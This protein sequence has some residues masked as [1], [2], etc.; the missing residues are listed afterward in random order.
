[1]A[2]TSSSR[3][4]TREQLEYRARELKLFLLDVDGVLT[5][6]GI[7]LS[8]PDRESKK[9]DVQDGMGI[10]LIRRAGV[11]VGLLTGRVSEAVR[12]RSEELEIDHVYQGHFWKDEALEEIVEQQGIAPE[13]MA[14]VGDDVLDL[15][16]MKRVGLPLAPANARP[17]VKQPAVY[18]ASESG[19]DGAVREIVDWL[20]ELR[21]E[22]QKLYRYFAREID[23]LE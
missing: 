11:E 9:F 3:N 18:V 1:M 2:S 14:Y 8:G 7:V 19:G 4:L 22:K 6:G 21:G 16:V 17:E 13:K 15:C 20:L 12:R 10:T 5:D 23:S